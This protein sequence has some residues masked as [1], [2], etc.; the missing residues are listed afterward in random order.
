MW[1]LSS[2][3]PNIL[4]GGGQLFYDYLFIHTKPRKSDISLF[5]FFSSVLP[6]WPYTHLC[7]D[8]G[9]TR[10][11]FILPSRWHSQLILCVLLQE[12]AASRILHFSK[13]PNIHLLAVVVVVGLKRKKKKKKRKE[14]KKRN[15]KVFSLHPRFPSPAFPS[16]NLK[17]NCPHRL[18]FRPAPSSKI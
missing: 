3:F 17:I 7:Y 2:P 14:R 10:E 12:R 16:E 9:L 13:A 6:V 8:P 1:I 4:G 18:P 11:S 5:H 15:K